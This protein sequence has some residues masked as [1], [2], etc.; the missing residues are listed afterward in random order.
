MFLTAQLK[1]IDTEFF[2]REN[3]PANRP[4]DNLKEYIS[5][6]LFRGIYLFGAGAM[7]G[8]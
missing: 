8:V 7:L 6:Q 2:S 3:I 1:K 5:C 4:A